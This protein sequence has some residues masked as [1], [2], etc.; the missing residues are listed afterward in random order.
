MTARLKR[1]IAAIKQGEILIRRETPVVG[2]DYLTF[3]GIARERLDNLHHAEFVRLHGT[4]EDAINARESIL[5]LAAYDAFP[6]VH[7]LLCERFGDPA[8]FGL[9]QARA[10]AMLSSAFVREAA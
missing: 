9:D 3:T 8:M 5:Y 6:S 4:L 1:A 10:E 7:D 2:P